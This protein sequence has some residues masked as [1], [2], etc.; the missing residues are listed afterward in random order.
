[1]GAREVVVRSLRVV[2]RAL[3]VVLRSLRGVVGPRKV[4]V[5]ARV[6]LNWEP[7]LLCPEMGPVS[8]RTSGTGA[9]KK[10]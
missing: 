4:V 1:M 5:R 3:R 2:V 8:V 10:R 7:E 6:C 9:W